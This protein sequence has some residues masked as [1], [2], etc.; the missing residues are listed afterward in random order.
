MA[1]QFRSTNISPSPQPTLSNESPATSAS[2]NH[3][4][5]SSSK[6][7]QVRRQSLRLTNQPIDMPIPPSL[8][9]SP[10]LN[11][12]KSIF[13]RAVTSPRHPSKEDEQWLQDT[14]P[15]SAHAREESPHRPRSMELP[16]GDTLDCEQPRGRSAEKRSILH[17]STLSRPLRWC[18]PSS[19]VWQ[20]KTRS[21][22]IISTLPLH[23]CG[24]VTHSFVFDSCSFML[25]WDSG[26]KI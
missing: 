22:S 18:H 20:E 25:S 14:V 5:R 2:P 19:A 3:L 15:L 1:N 17:H 6:Q 16:H 21:A 9:Q 24:Q 8:L 23:S 4:L 10:Y 12:P 11:S 13:K 7:R 26:K